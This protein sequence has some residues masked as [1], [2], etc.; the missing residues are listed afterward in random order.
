MGNQINW[1]LLWQK[2]RY[3]VQKYVLRKNIQRSGGFISGINSQKAEVIYRKLIELGY[4][5]NQIFS[6]YEPGQRYSVRKTRWH[7]TDL[8][9]IHIRVFDNEV[10]GHEEI[11]YDEGYGGNAK[12]HYSGETVREVPDKYKE[13][14]RH[15]IYEKEEEK[16]I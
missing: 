4:T 12:R 2:L 1:N 11:A 6:Y 16:K 10:R 14:I 13:E 8:Y 5:P 15:M 9:Q 3:Y 7:S